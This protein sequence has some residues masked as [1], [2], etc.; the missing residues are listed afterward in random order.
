MGEWGGGEENIAIDATTTDIGDMDTEHMFGDAFKNLLEL[1]TRLHESGTT[2]S[3]LTPLS[4]SSA[5]NA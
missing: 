3:A 4:I 2:C 1:H 5:L